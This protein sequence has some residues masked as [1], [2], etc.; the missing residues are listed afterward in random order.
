MLIVPSLVTSWGL[1]RAYEALHAGRTVCLA[2]P[3]TETLWMMD[4]YQIDTILAS[5]QQALELCELQEKSSRFPL[6][7]LKTFQIGASTISNSG[8]L[9]V[10][11]NLCRNVIMIYGST[12]AGVVAVAPH[13][14]IA[15]IPGAVGIIVAGVDVEIV[16]ASERPLPIGQEGFVRV[17]SEVFAENMAAAKSPDQWFYP[18]DLGSITAD[19]ILCIAGRNSE[20]VNRGG[21]KLS[22]LDIERFLSSCFGV[23]D[24]G[25]CT[26]MGDSGFAEVWV[27]LVLS[28]SADIGV[29]RHTIESNTQ[30]KNNIDKIFVVDAIPRGTLGKVQRDELK[31]M[32]QSIGEVA[33]S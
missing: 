20:V 1:S 25:V 24:A 22:I 5:P 29:L 2:R 7:A 3:G 19:N 6:S 12:E 18:G 4:T 33:A 31:K 10:K 13:D 28:P 23:N 8:V 17:R 16:D 14:M 21:E 26:V 9:R 30:F 27:A 15:D 11:Q 32:L